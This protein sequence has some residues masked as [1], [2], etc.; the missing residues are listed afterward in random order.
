MS[1]PQTKDKIRQDEFYK[2]I[3]HNLSEIR[4]HN[5]L[6]QEEFGELFGMSRVA[7]N[8]IEQGKQRLSVY[9]YAIICQHFKVHLCSL[10]IQSLPVIP[11][12]S[13]LEKSIDKYKQEVFA[14]GLTKEQKEGANMVFIGI[15]QIIKPLEIV[16]TNIID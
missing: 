12:K 11:F 9:H 1:Y 3:V 2:R 13:K 5:K 10:S 4:K 15:E 7:V 6:T 8:C 16:K 14:S